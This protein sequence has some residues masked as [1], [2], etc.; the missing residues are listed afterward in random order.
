MAE[1]GE[2]M[3]SLN[4]L[5]IAANHECSS[6]NEEER[7]AVRF[8]I[9][10]INN[11]RELIK[12]IQLYAAVMLID[13]LEHHPNGNCVLRYMNQLEELN[14]ADYDDRPGTLPDILIQAGEIARDAI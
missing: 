10:T 7:A 12:A 13:K 9:E 8:A 11:D 3:E 1:S 6:M 2:D 14:E 4:R 5:E